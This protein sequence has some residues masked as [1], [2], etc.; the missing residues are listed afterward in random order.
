LLVPISIGLALT[1]T[2]RVT[3]QTQVRQVRIR[4]ETRRNMRKTP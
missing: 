2:I 1:F 4:S 3:G